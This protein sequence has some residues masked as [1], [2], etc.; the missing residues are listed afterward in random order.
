MTRP[1]PDAAALTGYYDTTDTAGFD[2]P[3]AH[4]EGVA[5][6]FNVAKATDLAWALRA[7]DAADDAVPP[8]LVQTS[9]GLTVNRGDPEGDRQRIT[10]AAERAHSDL[11][12]EGFEVNMVTGAVSRRDAVQGWMNHGASLGPVL[13]VEEHQHD[14]SAG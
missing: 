10:A 14:R 12:A 11:R 13:E 7:M 2:A 5:A 6:A 9:P 4:I 8:N 3:H 1:G